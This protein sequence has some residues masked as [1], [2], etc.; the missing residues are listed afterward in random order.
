MLSNLHRRFPRTLLLY[1][2]VLTS[3]ALLPAERGMTAAPT[4]C[5]ED[6]S[7]P[8]LVQIAWPAAARDAQG[9]L[10]DLA[11][12]AAIKLFTPQHHARAGGRFESFTVKEGML[13]L[14]HLSEAMALAYPGVA[15][16]PIPVLAP[17]DTARFLTEAAG[18]DQDQQLAEQ[19]SLGRSIE[20]IQFLPGLSGYD[21]VLTVS[22]KALRDLDI[23]LTYKPQV[24]IAGTALSYGGANR[25]EPVLPGLQD[26]YPDLRRLLSADEVSYTFRKY[27]VPYFANVS[28]LQGPR[29][30]GRLACEQA[31]AIVHVVLRDLHLIGGGP[32]EI[33][34]RAL[35]VE[36]RPTKVS[37]TFKYRP[38]GRLLKG[39]SEGGGEMGDTT[40]KLHRAGHLGF[41][42]KLR[43]VYANSQVFMHSG[44]CQG[45]KHDVRDVPDDEFDHYKC[46]QNQIELLDFEGHR[47]NYDYPWRDNYCEARSGAPPGSAP[48]CPQRKGHAGQDLR[49][50]Y[51]IP[52]R[53]KGARCRIDVFEVVAVADGKAWW[54]TEP[55]ENHLRLMLDGGIYFM[56]LHMSPS[57]LW[58]AGM[59]RGRAIPV[60]KGQVIGMVGNFD[61]AVVGGTSTHLHFEIRYG[62]DIGAPVSPYWTLVRAYELHI[63]ARGTEVAD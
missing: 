47:E 8:E 58:N 7:L 48:G 46:G 19:A 3:Y 38:P 35:P 54:K 42:I 1:A 25:G 62:D 16:V 57:A 63:N 55:H 34:Q 43:P 28:C 27:G 4:P 49:P 13:P 37:A 12:P 2:T 24:H 18:A 30:P 41:P 53:D 26:L 60:T 61:K 32:L 59:E 15:A 9:L 56:Y 33:K 52:A 44:D 21:A 45:Q 36:P 40:C 17:V 5:V 23:V 11:A 50:W 10:P 31:D 29:L 22:A 20:G 14:A 39:T 6:V 51:C